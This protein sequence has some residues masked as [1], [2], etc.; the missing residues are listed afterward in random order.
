MWCKRAANEDKSDYR[1]QV[2]ILPT[3]HEQLFHTKVC[4]ADFFKI[5]F[6]SVIFWPKNIGAKAA[7]AHRL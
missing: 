3:F 6:G 1:Q 7:A 2:S 4:F 5:L